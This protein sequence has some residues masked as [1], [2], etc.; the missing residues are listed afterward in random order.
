[1]P[2][3]NHHYLLQ[4]GGDL[5][6]DEIWSNSIRLSIVGGV[7]TNLSTAQEAALLPTIKGYLTTWMGTSTAGW[8]NRTK[9]RYI[10]L[11][12][13]DPD[14]HYFSTTETNAAYYDVEPYVTGAASSPFP[15]AT[16]MVLSW[17]TEALR[18]RASKGRIFLPAPSLAVDIT[19]G[20][21][22]SNNTQQPALAAKT[23]LN[24]LRADATLAT[25]GLVPVVASKLGTGTIREITGVRVGN[26]PD[27]MR[28]RRNQQREA[29]YATTL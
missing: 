12:H 23:F 25:I 14:G 21:W 8:S 15:N 29:Y 10:K 22:S 28:S 7:V 13:V 11:N 9:L 4:F 16:S 6:P 2:Y 3:P 26:V 27:V 5:A 18:G 19:T 24:A 20:R 1:M 17:R